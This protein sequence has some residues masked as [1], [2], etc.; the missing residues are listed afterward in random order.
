MKNMA[1]AGFGWEPLGF[2]LAGIAVAIAFLRRQAKLADP[3][4]DLKLFRS[5]SFNAALG[6]NVLGIFFMFGSFIF[7]AQYFQLVAGTYSA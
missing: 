3:L 1:E 5:L 4:I 6:I 2:M 7:M